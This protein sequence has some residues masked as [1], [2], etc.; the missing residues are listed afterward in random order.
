MLTR[1]K[2]AGLTHAQRL[3]LRQAH[4]VEWHSLGQ[5]ERLC[6]GWQ[7]ASQFGRGKRRRCHL[8]APSRSGGGRQASGEQEKRHAQDSHNQDA[9][10]DSA[11]CGGFL[12]RDVSLIGS[13][14][15]RAANQMA[16]EPC[17]AGRRLLARCGVGHGAMNDAEQGIEHPQD[18]C[19][20]H[21]QTGAPHCRRHSRESANGYG[22]EM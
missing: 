13:R 14:G 4:C 8:A 7:E 1:G 17:A 22:E 11:R 19:H 6:S 20:C 21:W 2:D 16:D 10:I 3:S 5:D 15:V 18:Q 12:I 9:I